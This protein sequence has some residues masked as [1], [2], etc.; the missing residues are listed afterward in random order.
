MKRVWMGVAA[1]VLVALAVG[2]AFCGG[3]KLG[4]KQV[5]DNPMQ[6]LAGAGGAFS[7][8]MGEGQL[9]GGPS[10]NFQGRG[11]QFPG[12]QGTPGAGMVV[13][14][15]GGFSVD[16]IQA[17]DGNTITLSTA[18]GTVKVITSDT[19]Y[20]QKYM[21]ATVA[22]L[23]VGESVIVSGTENDDGSITARSIR[24]MTGLGFSED[25][26]TPQP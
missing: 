13:G 18:D 24:V 23:E 25:L 7:I 11:D 17:I 22:D 21:A 1:I 3:M 8:Q 9:P 2:A 15:R 12:A 5:I 26:A 6:Y 20:I 14:D 16:T 4:Q 19:T 10:G